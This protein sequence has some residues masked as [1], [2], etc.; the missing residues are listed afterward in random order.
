MCQQPGSAASGL[1]PAGGGQALYGHT[2]GQGG[3]GH[4]HHQVQGHL[5]GRGVPR[6]R[7]Q[8]AQTG[9]S[10]QCGFLLAAGNMHLSDSIS[11]D[12][13]QECLRVC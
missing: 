10:H 1:L 6:E 8:P 3:A 13:H 9:L 12:K 2:G 4:Q 5:R 7:P 11:D